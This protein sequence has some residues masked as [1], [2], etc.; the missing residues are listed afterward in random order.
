MIMV[1][2]VIVTAVQ[3]RDVEFRNQMQHRERDQKAARE[4]GH[5][6]NVPGFVQLEAEQVDRQVNALA[7]QLFKG[8]RRRTAKKMGHH[9]Q[10]TS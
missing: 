7:N 5:Y 9:P 2:S 1:V 6:A 8:Y 4:G 10:K 3:I